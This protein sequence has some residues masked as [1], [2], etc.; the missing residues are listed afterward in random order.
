MSIDVAVGGSGGVASVD[1]E[2]AAPLLQ[3]GTVGIAGAEPLLQF[4][5]GGT[6]AAAVIPVGVVI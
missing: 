4:G 6:E 1:I 2:G 5:A 3:A